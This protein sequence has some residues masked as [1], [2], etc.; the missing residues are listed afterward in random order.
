MTPEAIRVVS[1]LRREFYLHFSAAMKVP[2]RITGKSYSSNSPIASWIDDRQRLNY[3]NVYAH[4]APDQLLPERPFILRVAINKSAGIVTRTQGGERCQ[5]FNLYWNFELTVLPEEILDFLPWIVSLV[6]AQDKDSLSLVEEPP[7]PFESQATKVLV[8]KDA[9]TQ[10]AIQ[11]LQESDN[12]FQ[13]RD[14][15]G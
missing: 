5:G 12:L 4:T 3:V 14:A 7:Y 6:K 13:P 8:F 9:W 11:T 10:S 15:V 1:Q 2:V